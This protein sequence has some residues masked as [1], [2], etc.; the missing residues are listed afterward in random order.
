MALNEKQKKFFEFL[1]R[2][3][4]SNLLFTLQ[5]VLQATGWKEST[6]KSYFSKG[7]IT[8]FVS[9]VLDN[10]FEAS[11]SLDISFKQ[12]EKKLSQSKH[13]QSLGHNCK[14]K[15]AKALLRKSKDN[16]MLA[17]ELYNR[18]SLENKIDGF[19]MLFCVS[20]EQLLKAMLIENNTE[21]LIY[22]KQSKIGIKE[23]ISLR[24]CLNLVFP[25]NSSI[26]NNISKITDLRDQAV[27]LLMPEIQ[28]IASRLFQSGVFNYSSTFEEFC[29][30]PFINTDNT[31]MIS[32]VGDFKIPPLS[33]LKSIYGDAAEDILS[34]AANLTSS[35]E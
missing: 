33:M 12:F 27:H 29:Q 22:K 11:N 32:L 19:V 25:K 5:D 8:D 3:E 20:W 10:K 16:M 1:K 34:L 6:F 2:R 35:V 15:L 30:V 21:E 24:D 9:E 23:T 17:L 4:K 31:G 14:S 28:G 13:V 18:P 7:Q 26:K